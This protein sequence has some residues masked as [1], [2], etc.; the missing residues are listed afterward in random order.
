MRQEIKRQQLK[1]LALILALLVAVI[2]VAFF[3]SRSLASKRSAA[4]VVTRANT[5]ADLRNQIF[6]ASRVALGL[7]ATPTPA[8]P[9]GAVMDWGL[10]GGT[11]T[12]V[13]LSDGTAS[14]YMSSGGGSIGGGQAHQSVKIAAQKM[15]AIA[16][17]AQPQMR[18]TTT[19]PLP[20]Q[21]EVILYVL[22]DSG[23]FSASGT[24]DD[25]SSHH[26]PLSNL[27]DAAQNI[28]TLYQQEN[29]GK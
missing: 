19:F 17:A 21:G 8:Q 5:Y 28:I 23:V 1:A 7:P 4:N 29:E 27:G 24:Q 25:F 6:Q 11:V 3:L 15:V 22:T 14:V 20:Q 9:W 13:A 10:G 26:H 18:G 12:V 2:A 16:A